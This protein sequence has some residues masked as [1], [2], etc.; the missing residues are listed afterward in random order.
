[1]S[2]QKRRMFVGDWVVLFA[3]IAMLIFLVVYFFMKLSDKELM[4]DLMYGFIA[5]LTVFAVL[6]I[7]TG[8]IY[9]VKW[10]TDREAKPVDEKKVEVEDTE[11]IA[12]ISAAVA[13]SLGK[14]R[15]ARPEFV[16]REYKNVNQ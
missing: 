8:L 9:L 14:A 2:K 13:S 7:I 6:G 16:V 5:F 4:S 1:M 11:L 15:Q 12:V 3:L 10:I